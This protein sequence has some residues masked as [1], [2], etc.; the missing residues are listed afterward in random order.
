MD[1]VSYMY[2]FKVNKCLKKLVKGTYEWILQWFQPHIPFR[3]VAFSSRNFFQL[4]QHFSSKTFMC[5]AVITWQKECLL[6]FGSYI[7]GRHPFTYVLC[8][9]YAEPRFSCRYMY[10]IWN[11]ALL[12]FVNCAVRYITYHHHHHLFSSVDLYRIT[13]S[14]WIWKSS[15]LRENKEQNH[16]KV[17][18]NNKAQYNI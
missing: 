18:I 11:S 9:C 1:S 17:Y 7:M 16:Y 2:N 15:H 4:S 8:V 14:K 10:A 12:L 5:M 13:K 3:T 6:W